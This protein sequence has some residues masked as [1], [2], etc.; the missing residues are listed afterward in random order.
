MT[1]RSMTAHICAFRCHPT[2]AP[3]KKNQQQILG[4]FVYHC[5]WYGSVEHRMVTCMHAGPGIVPCILLGIFPRPLWASVL[6]DAISPTWI[7]AAAAA[8]G[9]LWPSTWGSSSFPLPPLCCACA[10]VCVGTG[11]DGP[12]HRHFEAPCSYSLCFSISSSP[13]SM[14][15]RLTRGISWEACVHSFPLPSK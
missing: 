6:A 15:V 13:G 10:C 14:A 1:P 11:E 7:W 3:L 12:Q 2:P 9:L 8:A 5:S 4:E